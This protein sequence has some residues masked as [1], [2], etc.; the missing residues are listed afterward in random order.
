MAEEV[1]KLTA[2]FAGESDRIPLVEARALAEAEIDLAR[3][4]HAKVA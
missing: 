3:V 4:R 1:E 2:M